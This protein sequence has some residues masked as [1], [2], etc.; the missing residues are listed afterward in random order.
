ML[1]HHVPPSD[2][3]FSMTRKLLPVLLE[4]DRQGHAGEAGADDE[5]VDVGGSSHASDRYRP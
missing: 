3:S 5:V 1:A 2:S 4:T